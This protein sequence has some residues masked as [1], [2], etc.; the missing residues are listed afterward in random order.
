MQPIAHMRSPYKEKF[1]IPRQPGLVKSALGVIE[2]DSDFDDPNALRGIE[3]FSHLWLIFE[4]HQT[5]AQGW[6]PLIRPPRLGGNSK[7]GVF[8]SRSTFR[9]NNLGMSVVEYVGHGIQR[10][11]LTLTVRGIDLLDGT[12][13]VD[14]KP[15][16][17]YADAIPGATG[18]YAPAA[19][20]TLEVQFCDSAEQFL[21][22]LADEGGLKQLITEVLA[23]DPR[24]G[25]RK[26]DDDERIYG[27]ALQNVNVRWQV[28]DGQVWV[29]SVEPV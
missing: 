12:P 23:Q 16:L 24:P 4:F 7:M 5:K 28:R 3:A 8:A 18:G 1:A 27:V 15:Y 14:I 9:P 20:V 2:F 25:Y 13:I 29:H 6:S 10:G 17:P 26:S 19:P 21:N 11:K 22:A